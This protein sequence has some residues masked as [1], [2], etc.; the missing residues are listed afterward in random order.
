M[1]YRTPEQMGI[2]SKDVLAFYKELDACRLSTHSVILCRGDSIFSEC[3]YAPFDKDFK[4]RMYSTTKSFVS[5]A[6][7]FCE[8]DGLL[9]LDDPMSKYFPEYKDAEFQHSA[10]IREML[11]MRTGREAGVPWFSAHNGDRASTYYLKGEQKFPNTLFAYDSPASY[12]LCVIVEKLTGKPFLEY[13]KEKFL[14]DTGFSPDAYCLQCPGGYSWGDSGILCTSQDLLR[15][16][17]FVL[18]GGTWNGK[19]YLNEEYIKKATY[20]TDGVTDSYGFHDT[21][22]IY[23][24]GYQ[25][26]GA[27]N[28]CFA[29]KGMGNQISLCDPEH[30]F[31]F[32]ITSCN[33]GNP[34]AYEQ[35]YRALFNNVINKL[36]D[37]PLPEDPE[38]KAELDAYI[39]QE[40]LFCL[41]GNPESALSE[42]VSGKVFTCEE[43]ETG[44]RWFRLDFN[45]DEGTF[46]YEN[47]QGEKKITFGFGHNVFHKFPQEGYSDMV[48][49]VV[50]PG[51][52][53][54]AAFSADWPAPY[55]L[56]LRVQI[57]D[58]YFGNLAILFSFRDENTVSVR[59]EKTA[60]HFLEEY[61]GTIRAKAK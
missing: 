36:S 53:Y 18:N 15:F 60:E 22:R 16:A 24:Y 46:T 32:V 47:A 57:I 7:G 21:H 1:N 61:K 31:I 39:A 48:G 52:Y 54:D 30:D 3:Y 29:T 27:P 58:K 35:I 42:K 45:G 23:G 8:Q 49:G 43:N 38:A 59:M 9:S 25:F 51:N 11:Q 20:M 56:R 5:I 14:N 17:R 50:C 40:K 55:T 28:G 12:M 4:H 26:W 37:T 10:T 2:S 6:V 44:I 19:R 41:P 33:E 13:L 34:L